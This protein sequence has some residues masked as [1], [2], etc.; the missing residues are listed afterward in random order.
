MYILFDIGGTNMRL[1]FSDGTNIIRQKTIPTPKD[2]EEAI[3]QF[4]LITKELAREEKIKRLAGG[5]RG[6]LNK[7]KS[8]LVVDHILNDWVNKPF[9][10]KLQN[11]Y[12][13]PVL[14]ENDTALVGLGEATKGAG[15]NQSI[16]AYVTI[17]TGVG[18][19]RIVNKKIDQNALGFEPGHQIIVADGS[20]CGCGGNGHLEAYISGYAIEKIHQ[21]KPQDLNNPLAWDEIAKYLS[22]GLNNTI[23]HWSPDIVVIGGSI[24]LAIPLDYIQKHLNKNLKIFTPPTVIKA[25]LKDEAG[26]LGA[27]QYLKQN[28]N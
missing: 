19:A 10:E 7:D 5:I 3:Y 8:K 26:L 1:A 12:Q 23:L 17:S 16:V 13:C 20:L 14:L 24:G 9:K 2:F 22:I 15:E 28:I 6:V 11:I 25:K 27:L 18:G 21:Q 4:E